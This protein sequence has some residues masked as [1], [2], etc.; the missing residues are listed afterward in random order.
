MHE[1]CSMVPGSWWMLKTCKFL[2]TGYRK[3]QK[4]ILPGPDPSMATGG[5]RMEGI[6]SSQ[7]PIKV[8][9]RA[10]LLPSMS[11]PHQRAK[12]LSKDFS[13]AESPLHVS[14]RNRV[15]CQPRN[16]L[17]GAP[18]E[19]SDNVHPGPEQNRGTVSNKGGN[20]CAWADS[21][22]HTRGSHASPSSWLCV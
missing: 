3:V 17:M 6:T 8:K 7:D 11:L 18:S 15:I 1:E 21:S 20:S 9:N 4:Q 22:A 5:C 12:N 14:G 19:K 16:E 2:L 13:P 10:C